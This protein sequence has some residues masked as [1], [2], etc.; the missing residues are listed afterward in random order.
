M[1]K[2]NNKQT[3]TRFIL[4]SLVLTSAPNKNNNNMWDELVSYKQDN[5]RVT[6]ICSRRKN[7]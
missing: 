1:Y 6:T 2:K 5:G 4:F 3:E 7:N